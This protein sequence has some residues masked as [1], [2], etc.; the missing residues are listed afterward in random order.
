MRKII[1]VDELP[2]GFYYITDTHIVE[3]TGK[4]IEEVM[5]HEGLRSEKRD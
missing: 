2:E 5:E 1:R 3:G 4:N